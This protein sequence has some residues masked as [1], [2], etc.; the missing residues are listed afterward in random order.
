V[1]TNSKNKNI[2]DLNRGI[3]DFKKGY[4]T[5]TNVV[6]DKKGNL[7]TDCHSIWARWR[8]HFCKLLNARWDN[9]SRQTAIHTAEPLM[10]ESSACEAEMATEKLK[11]TQITRW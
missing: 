2:R 7:V 9:D 3:S 4:Q 5:R 11:K 6:N 8:N 10:P 1:Q